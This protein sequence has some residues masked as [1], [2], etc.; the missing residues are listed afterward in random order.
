MKPAMTP[1]QEY[2]TGDKDGALAVYKKLAVG[3]GSYLDL[4]I[5]ELAL[6]GLS[7][8]P[9]LIG[10]GARSLIYPF[11]FRG[12]GKRPAIG[13]GVVI[14]QPKNI[15]LGSKVLIDDYC[16]LDVRGEKGEIVV[17]DFVSVGRYSTITAK[18]GKIILRQGTNIG[19]YTRI[20][21]Q[22]DVEVGESTLIAAYCYIGA[23]NHQSGDEQTPL[24]AREMEIKGGVKIGS[25][26]W[27]GAGAMILDGVTI[28]DGAIVGAQSLVRQDVPAGAVVAGTPAKIIKD[29]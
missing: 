6:V 22:S 26:C 15:S 19:S 21:T 5:Y 28:G 10:L 7:G 8:L 25:H 9:G 12:C 16:A 4:V 20:A 24:I 11:M 13:R 27:I 23:G 29:S 3:E 18:N 17:E 2:L 1:Q 14:R